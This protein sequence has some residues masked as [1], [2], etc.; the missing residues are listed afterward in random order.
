MTAASSLASASAAA[1][2]TFTASADN[3]MLHL[4]LAEAGDR[5]LA[6]PLDCVVGATAWPARLE[7]LP[8]R[9]GAVCGLIEHFGTPLA[10]LD[11]ALWVELGRP[12][13][14][15]PT[16][17]RALLLRQRGRSVA[18]GVDQLRGLQA[19]R[20]S[21]V[22]RLHYDDDGAQIFHSTVR[23]PGNDQ[24]ASLLDVDRLMTLAQTWSALGDRERAGEQ[25]RA[26]TGLSTAPAGSMP[27]AGQAV[28]AA[29]VALAARA[30]SA[31]SA[32]SAASAASA[33]STVSTASTASAASVPMQTV[34]GVVPGRHGRIGFAVADLAAVVPAPS[35]LPFHS[36]R[37]E[38]LCEWR[39]R[40]VPVTSI[41][42]CFPELAADAE[43][44]PTLMAVFQHDGL[45]VGLLL[46]HLPALVTLAAPTDGATLHVHGD[47]DGQ[48]TY[49]LSAQ[50][51]HA[52]IP[53]GALSRQPARG[54]SKPP[55]SGRPTR[56]AC[57]ST[58]PV[59]A[60]PLR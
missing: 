49:L 39:G 33:V 3:D 47:S 56:K 15:S 38:G 57:W 7:R 43:A 53:E 4:V 1:A 17:S 36:P 25:A 35:L 52:R 32:V 55:T 8:R 46:H 21:A 18:I 41:A 34:F 48:L 40:H 30:V 5:L 45:F 31:V 9:G 22:V 13:A 20:P 51:L 23:C 14:D 44:A 16:Y 19:V 26:S 50:L 42:K 24:L 2:A 29:G 54:P 6:L 37:T 59:A 58:M 28:E 12:S 10:L 27:A 60:R 11:L